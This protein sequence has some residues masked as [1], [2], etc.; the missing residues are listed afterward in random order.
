MVHHPSFSPSGCPSAHWEGR[1]QKGGVRRMLVRLRAS[2]GSRDG[3]MGG[4]RKAFSEE[5]FSV[6]ALL[7]DTQR[8]SC[9]R[10]SFV[11]QLP[12]IH[13]IQVT[14]ARFIPWRVGRSL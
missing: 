1:M 14:K 5:D 11:K 12:C 9:L 8:N 3:N 6:T 7:D 4:R 10:P 2:A 13:F